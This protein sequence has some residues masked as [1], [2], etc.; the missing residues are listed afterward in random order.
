VRVMR[1]Q[2]IEDVGENGVALGQGLAVIEPK[3]VEPEF[4]QLGSSALVRRRRVSLEV[5]TAV[6]FDDKSRLDA[7]KV[8]EVRPDGVL[9]PE[10]VAGELSVAQA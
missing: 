5:L 7:R 8:S 3:D 6:Q 9:T 1:S 2:P 4:V 10:L